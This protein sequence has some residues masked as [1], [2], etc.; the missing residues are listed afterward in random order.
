V[1]EFGKQRVKISNLRWLIACLLLLA[2][3]LNYLDRTALSVVSMDVRKEFGLK[4]SDYGHVLTLFLA[5]YAIMY[6]G[7][8]YIVDRLGT[9]RLRAFH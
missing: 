7:S 1:T 9:K 8:G 2:T 3:L 6:A 5:A 4:E